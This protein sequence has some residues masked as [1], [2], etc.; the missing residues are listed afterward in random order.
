MDAVNDYKL[1][2]SKLEDAIKEQEENY[3][4]SCEYDLIENENIRELAEI[5]NQ[6]DKQTNKEEYNSFTRS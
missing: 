2:F 6:L 3:Q 4:T 1:L 5:C